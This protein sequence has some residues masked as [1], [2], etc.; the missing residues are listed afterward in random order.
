MGGLANQGIQ[1]RGTDPDS[2]TQTFAQHG[3]S[4]GA[5]TVVAFAENQDVADVGKHAFLGLKIL[6]D[7]GEIWFRP[8]YLIAHTS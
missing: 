7:F 4:Q 8:C 6:H 2:R 3:F 1:P 5:A